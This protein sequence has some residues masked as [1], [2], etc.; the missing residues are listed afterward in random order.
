ME[1]PLYRSLHSGDQGEDVAQLQRELS[2]L[3]LF[4]GG[5]T[6]IFDVST[7]SAVSSLYIRAGL[8]AQTEPAATQ[9]ADQNGKDGGS[10]KEAPKQLVW[11]PLGEIYSIEQNQAQV[12][13]AVR[14]GR[15]LEGSAPV[16]KLRIGGL[17][18]SVRIGVDEKSHYK[19]GTAV[20]LSAPELSDQTWRGEVTSVGP[21]DQGSGGDGSELGQVEEDS[22]SDSSNSGVQAELPGYDVTIRLS[23]RPQVLTNGRK[24]QVR[25]KVATKTKNLAVPL[26]AI[27]QDSRG[28]YVRL[29]PAGDGQAATELPVTVT[30]DADGWAALEPTKDLQ[31]G[32]S[33]QVTP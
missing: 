31:P 13:T 30:S 27:R 11:L 7:M 33:V 12:D 18:V 20:V 28:T 4:N 25:P 14:R 32:D 24:V 22:D 19:A 8:S 1:V 26:I 15:V 21:F 2:R 17:R 5:V 10:T 3:G 9:K 16:V 6:K 23:S 29:A